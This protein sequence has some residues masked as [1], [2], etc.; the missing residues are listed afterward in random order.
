MISQRQ[1]EFR[2][3]YRSRILGWYDG[4]VHLVIIY[5]MGAAA[6]TF[7]SSIFTL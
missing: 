5:A 1:I 3:D 6:S 7:T 4:Y 2:R